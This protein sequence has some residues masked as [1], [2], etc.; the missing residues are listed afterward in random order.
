[1]G[2]FSSENREIRRAIKEEEKEAKRQA[3]YLE[4]D[5]KRSRGDCPCTNTEI[6]YK[7]GEPHGVYCKDCGSHRKI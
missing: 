7:H 4:Q 1:M 3:K 2:L 5:E 6:T